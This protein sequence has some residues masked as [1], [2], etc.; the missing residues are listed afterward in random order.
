MHSRW[1]EKNPDLNEAVVFIQSLND[2]DKSVVAYH[3]LQILVNECDIN[4]DEQFSKFS[5]NNYSYRRW[6]DENRELS[7]AFELLK[8]LSEEKQEYVIN[9]F[10]SEI[11]MSFVKKEL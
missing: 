5:N 6:Y 7:T 4:I 1:Y 9:R 8:D 2:E 3:L 11:V 10:L